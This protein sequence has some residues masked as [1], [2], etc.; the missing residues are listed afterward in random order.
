MEGL[1]CHLSEHNKLGYF[2][3]FSMHRTDMRSHIEV[4]GTFIGWKNLQLVGMVIVLSVLPPKL[5][6]TACQGVEW[7]GS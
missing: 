7:I 1:K 2:T 5:A 4:F 3:F 6:V